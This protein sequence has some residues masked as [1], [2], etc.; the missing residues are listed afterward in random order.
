MA[1]FFI[2]SLGCAKNLVD[3][4]YM[5]GELLQAGWQMAQDP[6][7]SDCIIINTCGFI[8]PAVEEGIDE[9]LSY[10]EICRDNGAKLVVVGC[11]V[12]RYRDSLLEE[13]PEVDLFVGM[14][15][16]GQFV[17][18]LET[19]F[20]GTQGRLILPV[21]G[22]LPKETD[23]YVSTPFYRAW[24]KIT[25]GCNNRCSYCLIPS[26]RGPLKSRQP[27]DLVQ[28]AK[29]LEASGVREL[30]II[31][32]DLTSYGNDLLQGVNLKTFLIYFS[33]RHLFPG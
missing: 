10:A 8:Q 12:Q 28:E 23:R 20:H 29:Y 4:E 27:A 33:R 6:Q 14:E 25:E 19:L 26:I 16:F 18:I 1:S 21:P 7:E 30:S 22:P 3:S 13:L 32:Q 11:L 2:V 15:G 5:V 17:N 31:A 24:L 9:I